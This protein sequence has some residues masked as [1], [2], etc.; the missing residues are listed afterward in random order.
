MTVPPE[1]EEG[2]SVQLSA[3]ISPVNATGTVQ[4]RTA[5]GT[6]G[7]RFGGQGIASTSHTFATA[8]S[9]PITA[10]FAGSGGFSNSNLAGRIVAYLSVGRTK[11]SPNT[12]MTEPQS[13]DGRRG[14]A[15]VRAGV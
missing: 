5:R 10:T 9:K 3:S 7:R 1:C 15:H 2:E 14:G 4:F 12:I 13:A 6:S 11:W 8:G